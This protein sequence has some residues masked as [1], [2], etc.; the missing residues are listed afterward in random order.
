MSRKRILI[1]D[2]NAHV[3]EKLAGLLW[4][5]G[6]DVMVAEDGAQTVSTVRTHWPDL[7][8]LNASLPTEADFGGGAFEDGFHVIAWLKRLKEAETMRIILMTDGD[9]TKLHDKARAS[10]AMGLC[11]KPIHPETLLKVIRQV[12]GDVLTVDQLSARS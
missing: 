8:I 4:L 3:R 9:A 11:Q 2:G 6:Y 1:T 5:E 10:G 12:M 7:L